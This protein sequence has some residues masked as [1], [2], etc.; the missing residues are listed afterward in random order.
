MLKGY[1]I[2]I[3]ITFTELFIGFL[4]LRIEY[5]AI[6]ALLIAV[7]DILPV[8]GTG[9]VL[10]PWALV[11]F[12][13][14]KPVIGVG[15]LILYLVITLIRNVIEPKI[16]GEQVGLPPV[17]TLIAMYGGLKLFGFTGLWGLPVILIVLVNL[18]DAGML[19][20][21]KD[22]TRISASVAEERKE[23]KAKN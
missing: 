17:V 7:V 5:A 11:D 21:W 12:A 22:G 23:S 19:R 8:L 2:V 4:I 15:I 1:T 13:I 14:G 16:I 6:L 20:I 3:L 18:Q 10:I 9:V